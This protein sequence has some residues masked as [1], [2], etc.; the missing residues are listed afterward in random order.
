MDDPK[1][2]DLDAA[3]A[4]LNAAS[5]GWKLSISGAYVM[6]GCGEG[7]IEAHSKSE[8]SDLE[9]LAHVREDMTHLIAL[10]RHYQQKEKS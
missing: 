1:T 5:N 2:F 9:F 4:R 10:V 3:E 6:I 8:K 7:W